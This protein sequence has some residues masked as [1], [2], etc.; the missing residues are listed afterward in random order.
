[1]SVTPGEDQIQGGF[2]P[3]CRMGEGVGRGIPAV[4]GCDRALP[5]PLVC[6]SQ[7]SRTRARR[8]ESPPRSVLIT[9]EDVQEVRQ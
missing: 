2:V 1:M 8:G 5:A 4:P 3:L 7:A 9:Q 6:Q